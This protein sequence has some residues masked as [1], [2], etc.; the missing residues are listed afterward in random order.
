MAGRASSRQDLVYAAASAGNAIYVFSY[1]AGKLVKTIR[2]P[3]GTVSLQGLCSDNNGN[4]YVTALAAAGSGS[5]DD[6]MLYEYKR[7]A[8]T[9]EKTFK[10]DG[11]RPFGC[12]VDPTTGDLAFATTSLGVTAGYV[13]IQA[14][15]GSGKIYYDY[16]ISNYYYCDFD[17][18]GNL[19]V[20]GQGDGTEMYLAEIKKGSTGYPTNLTLSK[21]IS[22]S[23]MGQIQWDGTDITLEDLTSG[24]IDRLEID[25]TRA[26]IVG[27]TRLAK[28]YDATLSWING[29][30]VLV[31]TG[32]D[33]TQV[34]VW[35]YPQGGKAVQT[36]AAPSSI[37]SV[38]LSA[39]SQR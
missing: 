16:N 30:T 35:N 6:G 5:S 31:P 38:T 17:G 28:W 29:A 3:K 1:P 7:G 13:D 39:V 20:D 24:A 26:N 32:S 21:S 23:G 15:D 25:G 27:T 22:L 2:P 37:F 8:G 19:F 12:A 10:L 11:V 9:P 34:G 14:P 33:Q 18:S 4:V 36:I